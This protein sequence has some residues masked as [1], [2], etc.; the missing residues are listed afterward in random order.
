MSPHNHLS[1][2]DGLAIEGRECTFRHLSSY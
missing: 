2:S 1:C